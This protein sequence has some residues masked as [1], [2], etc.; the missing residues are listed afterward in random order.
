MSGQQ[1]GHGRRP[2]TNAGLAQLGRV[3]VVRLGRGEDLLPAMAQLLV[4]ASMDTGVILG[5]VASLEHA[6][7]RNIFRLPERFPITAEDRKITLVPG[8]LEILALQGNFVPKAG[9]GVAIH[10]HV[11]FSLGA[12]PAST[13]GGHL[14]ENTIVATT[15]ELFLGELT[16]LGITRTLDPSTQASEIEVDNSVIR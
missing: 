16:G 11:E 9:G 1:Y 4:D 6:T 7:V 13:Y 8:P 12:P 14:I 5:A 10:A 15:C 3:L 2:G